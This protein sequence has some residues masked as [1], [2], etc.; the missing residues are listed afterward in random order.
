MV[1]N[2]LGGATAGAA[3]E[4]KI[5]DFTLGGAVL[6]GERPVYQSV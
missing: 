4:E 1:E 5:L 2:S 3:G 6:F